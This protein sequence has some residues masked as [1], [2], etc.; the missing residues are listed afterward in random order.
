MKHSQINYTKCGVSK[1]MRCKNCGHKLL[2]NQN[3]SGFIHDKE[4]YAACGNGVCLVNMCGCTNPE[5]KK[6]VSFGTNY[7]NNKLFS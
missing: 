2:A 1:K 5:P 7:E 6:E 4:S 3:G